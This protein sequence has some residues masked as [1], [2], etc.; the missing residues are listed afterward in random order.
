MRSSQ[1]NSELFGVIKARGLRA[2]QASLCP[3]QLGEGAWL[4]SGELTAVLLKCR[5]PRA[6]QKGFLHIPLREQRGLPGHLLNLLLES[7]GDGETQSS[8][9]SIKPGESQLP[10]LVDIPRPTKAHNHHTSWSLPVSNP[11]P[12]VPEIKK[13]KHHQ[14][15][16]L[17]CSPHHLTPRAVLERFEECTHRPVSISRGT[18]LP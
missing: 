17:W 7:R 16:Q 11:V 14:K 9:A 18:K 15:T 12:A 3:L 6:Q 2:H 4:L 1:N 10:L 8:S 13:K 5:S